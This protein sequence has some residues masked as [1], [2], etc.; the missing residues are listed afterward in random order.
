MIVRYREGRHRKRRPRRLSWASRNPVA[1]AY[2]MASGGLGAAVLFVPPVGAGHLFAPFHE[3]AIEPAPPLGT[4]LGP[5]GRNGPALV[6]APKVTV[7]PAGTW[8]MASSTDYAGTP[9]AALLPAGSPPVPDSTGST[10][11]PKH[12]LASTPDPVRVQPA[13]AGQPAALV[14]PAPQPAVDQPPGAT[15]QSNGTS[16]ATGPT[17]STAGSGYSTRS[18]PGT[19][20]GG[21]PSGGGTGTGTTSS[22]SGAPAPPAGQDWATLAAADPHYQQLTSA[23]RQ[24]AVDAIS[25]AQ[26]WCAAR[27]GACH[28]G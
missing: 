12:A 24:K 21:T 13:A 6:T 26:A 10:P 20:P 8:V 7:H 2:V 3:P 9:P 15:A 22:G 27:P 17:T 14:R 18:A 16:P 1:L 19:P 23:Q 11:M 5:L 25:T 4:L 28:A